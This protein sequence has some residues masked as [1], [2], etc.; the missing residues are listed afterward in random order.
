MIA[1]SSRG[2]HALSAP[3]A[4]QDCVPYYRWTQDLMLVRECRR[5]THLSPRDL[6]KD[7]ESSAEV[8]S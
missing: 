6:L 5:L 7:I 2:T 3:T 1:E 8:T 4:T